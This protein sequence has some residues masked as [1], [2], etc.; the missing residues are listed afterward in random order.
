MNNSDQSFELIKRSRKLYFEKGSLRRYCL[1]DEIAN[2][3]IK[4]NLLKNQDLELT[5][6]FSKKG[7]ALKLVS[8]NLSKILEEY[9]YKV[10]IL[11]D[12]DHIYNFAFKKTRE[13]Y[14]TGAEIAFKLKKD[15]T[16]F[17]EEH[18][19]E[20]FDD[21]FT[22]GFFIKE[23]S[24][25]Y[26][27]GIYG[28][29][30]NYSKTRINE[31]K[32]VIHKDFVDG[33]KRKKQYNFIDC[34][35]KYNQ[36]SHHY[37]PVVLIGKTGTGKKYFVRNIHKKF[38]LK[39][40][41]KIIECK[42]IIDIE[43]HL[44]CKSKTLLYLKN[45]EWLT[46][47]NQIKL[48]GYIDSKLVNSNVNKSSDKHNLILFISTKVE[49]IEDGKKE[50]VDHRLLTRLTANN[51]Y[52]KSVNRYNTNKV[53]QI[54]ENETNR[55]LTDQSK[56]MISEFSWENNWNDLKKMIEYIN[57]H[58]NKLEIELIDLPKFLSGR[59]PEISTI[60]E[61]EKNLV[62]RSL[63]VFDENVSLASKALGISRST[64]Y[65]KIKEY[66]LS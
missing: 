61:A 48:A 53:F 55:Q 28:N 66:D 52:F 44:N 60:K 13:Y 20:K 63:K 18:I 47:K 32:D 59:N 64:L 1:R 10:Y 17:K 56:E 19:S 58:S 49:A 14:S 40:Q 16:V 39:R 45:I 43:E 21:T 3:W 62:K 50:W 2:S 31:I 29:Y 38:Y 8:D 65:R 46:Y 7:K 9:D 54:V 4:Y 36:I 6:S 25:E 41:L 27:L 51:I 42:D 12:N 26:I 24:V 57:E 5:N 22:H 30:E 33:K 34:E 35:K 11:L 37:L 15:F 23:G